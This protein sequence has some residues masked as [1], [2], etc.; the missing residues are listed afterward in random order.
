[1]PSKRGGR[2]RAPQHN[3]HQQHHHNHHVQQTLQSDYDT[4]VANMTDTNA[5]VQAQSPLPVPARTN[6]DLNLLVLKR[7]CP[8]VVD[9]LTVANFAVVY[10]FSPSSSQWEKC[11]IEG[12]LFVCR[13]ESEFPAGAE[14]PV[15]RYNVIVLNRKG[16]DN[17][18]TDVTSSEAVQITDEYIIVDDGEGLVYGLWIF[19]EPPPSSTAE[20]RQRTADMIL[21]CAVRAEKSREVA[22]A[23]IKAELAARDVAA[24][25]SA[26]AYPGSAEHQK[27]QLQ[28]D[29][30]ASFALG[31]SQ[32][33]I[34]NGY[35]NGNGQVV[36]QGRQV[37]IEELFGQQH[38]H[39][40]HPNQPFPYPRQHQRQQQQYQQ[41]Q[42]FPPQYQHQQNLLSQFNSG[43]GPPPPNTEN[44]NRN[45]GFHSAEQYNNHMMAQQ[46]AQQQQFRHLQHLHQQQQQ[47][48]QQQMHHQQQLQQH[49]RQ[50]QQQQ[51][52]Q[53]DVIGDLFRNAKQGYT[54]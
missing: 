15:E 21:E 24:A 39:Q 2:T 50:Q 46:Q 17:F 34:E 44:N 30:H 11:G 43:G 40:Q 8:S 9:I 54:A 20:T 52:Q 4:D 5:P 38:Q 29:P 41:H 1:M 10:T 18:S 32:Q 3:Q 35:G 13:L 6:E 33:H 31:Q 28:Q 25:A 19:S 42:H 49:Q 26:D 53:R 45:N 7:H 51:Q 47:Q 12:T 37:G 48:Q 23:E 22:E 14:T 27:Q 16:L 36:P